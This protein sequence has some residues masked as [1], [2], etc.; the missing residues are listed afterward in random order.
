MRVLMTV[1][2]EG[3]RVDVAL[4]AD[5]R[6]PIVEIARFLA[7]E[8]GADD[9]FNSIFNLG[10][11]PATLYVGGV[12]IPPAVCLADSPLRDGVVVGLG[13][14]RACPQPGPA[15]TV[16]VRVTGGPNAGD[17]YR[18]G[19]GTA[20]V[21]A[22]PRAW[23]SLP[24]LAEPGPGGVA[25]RLD[26]DDAGACTVS[27]A[28]GV[29]AFLDGDPL[30]GPTPWPPGAQV[31]LGWTALQLAAPTHP[32]AALRP[33]EDGAGLD[34]NRPPRLA[35]QPWNLRLQLP[36][37]PVEQDRR[38]LPILIALLPLAIMAPLVVIFDWPVYFLMF[39][40]LGPITII[41]NHVYER[42]RN[43]TTD[44][45]KAAEYGERKAAL[46][47]EAQEALAREAA[48]RRAACPDPAALNLTATGP[49]ER[50]WERRREDDDHLLLRIGS[51][52]LPSESVAVVDP[53]LDEHRRTVV[54]AVRDVP[55]TVALRACGVLG[56]A[57]RGD[58][59]RAVGRWL[60]AQL[61]VLHSPADVQV[62]VL[63][64]APGARECWQWVRWPPHCRARG[65]QDAVTFVGNDPDSVSRRLTELVEMVAGRREA[66]RAAGGDVVFADPDVVVL[67][68]GARRLRSLPKTI[69]LL[70]D[71]PAVGVYLICLD[72]ERRHLPAECRAVVE[73]TPDGGLAV[74][75]SG[76]Q[77]VGGVRPD[78]VSPDWCERIAR[79]LAPIRDAGGRE[80]GH[81]LPAR[82]RLLDVLGMDPPSGQALAARWR[83]G[84]RTTEAVVGL[85]ED[86]PFPIDLRHDGPHGLIGGTTGSGKSE[87]LQ[88]IVAS[89]A[90]ANRPDAMTFVLVDYKGGAA[91]AECVY[92]PHTV[93]M[94]TDLD[95]HLVERALTSLSA[96]LN[97]REHILARAGAKNIDDYTAAAA[98]SPG[99][100]PL[101]R[102]LI[103]IDEFASMVRDLPD[104]VTGL[105]NIAQRGR[106]LGIHLLLATQRPAGV[107]SADI[108]AN[109]NL[110]IALRVLDSADSN[111]VIDVADAARISRATPGRA[112]LR[113]GHSALVPFQ[114]ARV[115][116]RAPSAEARD[117]LPPP[118]LAE[119]SWEKAGHPMPAR[120]TR[121]ADDGTATDLAL[122]VDAAREAAA[123]AG[124]PAQHSPWL[125]ALAENVLLDDVTPPG[126]PPP[127]ASGAGEL[128]PV[129]YALEDLPQEQAQRG[130]TLD[131]ADFGHLFAAGAPRSGRS[132]LLR[133]IAASA[134]RTHTCADVHLYAVDCG[135]G[136]LLPLAELPHCG[137]VV[138]TT[139][140]DRVGR[141]IDRLA[142]EV[143]RRMTLLGEHGFAD[144]GEQR[145]GSPPERRLPHI[146]V[147]LDRWEGFTAAIGDLEGG[148]FTDSLLAMLREGASVGVHLIVTGDR[149]LLA[150]RP[151]SLTDNK[152]AFRLPDRTDLGLIG[153]NH[154]KVAATLPPGRAFRS[155]VGTELQVALLAPDPTGAAQN[156][157]IS[158]VARA[159]RERDA[160]VPRDRRP[161]RVDA[162]PSRI[163]FADAWAARDP[164][165]QGRPLWGLVAVGGDDLAGY[166]PDLAEGMPAFVIAGRRGAGRTTALLTLARSYLLTGTPV[167]VAAPRPSVSP[168]SASLLGLR[169]QP[170]VVAVFDRPSLD[171]DPLR[172]ALSEFDGGPGVLLI[173]DGEDLKDCP[174]GEVFTE[175][176][177]GAAGPVGLVLAGN[178]EYLCRGFGGWQP[179]VKQAGRGLLLSPENLNDGELIGMTRLRSGQAGG[180]VVPGRGFLN[181]GDGNLLTVQ[182]PLAEPPR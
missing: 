163:T 6:T 46:E 44:A 12:P 17:V 9:A 167:I 87:L 177:R 174:A 86:G 125:P 118:R 75:R 154:R 7:S 84:G 168:A 83:A 180:P 11:A 5:E 89:L 117:Q 124:V 172:T 57:G 22:D 50:L 62:C 116:G 150:G 147:L 94:V 123:L 140:P 133:T 37:K 101:P 130:A 45:A 51:A 108:R 127:A 144:I 29:E 27:P 48:E 170:G 136:A 96:E 21:G 104:F 69:Q 121:R 76:F 97:R 90:T 156:A 173:D 155:E 33:S 132:Q 32:N 52:D 141:L 31:T 2:A 49:R 53:S 23:V 128:A 40:L 143:R 41:G 67:V 171:A 149:S 109:T 148:R 158:A 42:R 34:Y 137:A 73:A 178:A 131:F 10:G 18:R 24:D 93:G 152:I 72:V 15:G 35:P 142:A 135:N 161:F 43:R 28:D 39:S 59:P 102:L 100:T 74:H 8:L 56:V 3:L 162:L 81:D 66:R 182:V 157:A 176:L 63:S 103:V 160:G 145:A 78:G 105:V 79:A 112:Y 64:E 20:M 110:R 99:L 60:L 1:A 88:T 36:N 61:A 151:A 85:G 122:L 113:L 164:G 134:A 65:G 166:G 16:E 175:V 30:A 98:S 19:P 139:E 181:L 38:P 106:S 13:D 115:G 55:V 92:L 95:P 129:P 58:L 70:R 138:R 4:D 14:P 80:D 179:P 146:L 107:V 91:F 169:G 119:I 68:D 165:G 82:C 114:A 159:A 153:V 126:E 25:L 120:R 54:P 47:T 77:P 111:D 26:V 71:G